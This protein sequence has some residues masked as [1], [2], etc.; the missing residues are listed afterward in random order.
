MVFRKNM[1]LFC[2]EILLISLSLVGYGQNQNFSGVWVLKEKKNVFGPDYVNGVPKQM[3]IDFKSD[4]II[5]DRVYN[6][7]NNSE[8]T[9]TENLSLDGNPTVILRSNS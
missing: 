5:I 9:I 8:Y 3:T 4:S 7:S 6:G 2:S 1:L